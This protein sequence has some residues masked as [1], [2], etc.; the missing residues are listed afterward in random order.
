MITESSYKAVDFTLEKWLTALSLF[1]N[2]N[3]VTFFS[4]LALLHEKKSYVFTSDRS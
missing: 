1:F 2:L 4:A 3:L